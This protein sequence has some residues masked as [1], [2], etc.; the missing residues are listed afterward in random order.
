MALSTAC[1]S[2]GKS[3]VTAPDPFEIDTI[4]LMA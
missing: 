4:V 3:V 1:R 2:D